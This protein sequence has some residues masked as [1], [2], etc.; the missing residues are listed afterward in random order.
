M[1]QHIQTLKTYIL[2]SIGVYQGIGAPCHNTGS[3]SHSSRDSSVTFSHTMCAVAQVTQLVLAELWDA[4][5]AGHQH[6]VHV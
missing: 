3:P 6:V 1:L 5:Q 2:H 4:L